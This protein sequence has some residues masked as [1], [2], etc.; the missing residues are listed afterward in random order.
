MWRG[1]VRC[2]ALWCGTVRCGGPWEMYTHFSN[3]WRQLC[4]WNYFE[5]IFADGA[6]AAGRLTVS[7]AL[8]FSTGF[9]SLVE[10]RVPTIYRIRDWA[11]R[12]KKISQS[13]QAC[14]SPVRGSLQRARFFSAKTVP[15]PFSADS[16][17]RQ[18][19]KPSIPVH[20][21]MY[22]FFFSINSRFNQIQILI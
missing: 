16:L 7:E 19:K 18:I 10:S 22:T 2:G 15:F 11:I 13:I 21:K 6:H 1:V 8:A 4:V 20:A 17:L 14:R 12:A 5:P 9:N 3:T